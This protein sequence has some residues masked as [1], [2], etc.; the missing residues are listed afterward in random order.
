MYIMYHR[1]G[2]TSAKRTGG[3]IS[4]DHR[5]LQTTVPRPGILGLGG[6]PHR[7]LASP[8]LLCGTAMGQKDNDGVY[9]YL[10][11]DRRYQCQLYA[12]F[13]S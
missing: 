4:N 13:G 1:F 6:D 8:D 7:H 12:G 11:L 2:R 9:Q 10:F 5:E 3:A